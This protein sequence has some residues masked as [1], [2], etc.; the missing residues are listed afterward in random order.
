[1]NSKRNCWIRQA[2]A[3][4]VYAGLPGASIAQPL[5][6][7]ASHSA[8]SGPAT[9][10]H[11]TII[12]SSTGN[13][14][15]TVNLGDAAGTPTWNPAVVAA[16]DGS[17]VYVTAGPDLVI[18]N[19]LTYVTERL[20]LG[21][22]LGE[23]A[24]SADGSRLYIASNSHASIFVVDTATLQPAG[25]PIAV[26]A[27]PRQLALT[28]DGTRLYVLGTD[29]VYVADTTTRAV[30]ASLATRP[31]A[32]RIL[33]HPDGSRLY[34]GNA[35]GT[36]TSPD[37]NSITSYDTSTLAEIKTTVFPDFRF[38]AGFVL[39]PA[40][41][42]TMAILP[43]GDRLYVPLINAGFRTSPTAFFRHEVVHVVDSQT[44]DITAS[45]TPIRNGGTAS[46]GIAAAVSPGGTTVFVGVTGG[47]SAIEVGT[48]AVTVAGPG[49]LNGDS[50]AAA[51]APPCWFELSPQ[52][53][54]VRGA[55]GSVTLNVPAPEG[56]AWNA[57]VNG[58]PLPVSATSGT[59]SSTITLQ[60]GSSDVPRHWTVTIAGQTLTIDQVISRTSIETPP[61]GAGLPLPFD[62][63]GWTIEQDARVPQAFHSGVVFGHLYDHPV[64]GPAVFLGAIGTANR[65]PDIA[66]I[67]GERY[68]FSGF[69]KRIGRLSA[70][71]HTL[72]VYSLSRND[73]Q[74]FGSA[75]NVT[76]RRE[77]QIV[78]DSPAQ[79]ATVNQ[80]FKLSGWAADTTVPVGSGVDMVRVSARRG[81]GTVIQLGNATY[82]INRGDVS[83]YFFD[84]GFLNLGFEMNVSGL[85]AGTYTLVAEAR[86]TATGLFEKSASVQV[87]VTGSAPFGVIDTPAASA[88]V[89]G[90]VLVT[91]WALSDVGVAR[92]AVYRD[93]VA[94]ESGQ[95]WIG[96][97]TFVDGARPDVAA[98][99]PSY[100]QNTRAGW[101][102]AVLTNMLPSG[103][104]GPITFHVYAHD[105]NNNVTALGARSV[106]GANGSSVQP[107]GTIDTPGQGATVSGTITVFGW[108]LT[109]GSNIIPTDGST[110]QVVVD[111]VV[112]GQPTYNQCRG[113]NGT[114]FPPPGTCNDDIAAAFGSAYRNIAAGSGAIGS[115]ELDT[116][117]L[118]NGIHSIEW[119]VTDS[120]GNVQGIGSRYFYVQNGG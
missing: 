83:L 54:Y 80:P 42:G 63:T 118:S 66:A 69:S 22:V 90:T 4:L 41:I 101:G 119:R 53:S 1:M 46:T 89:A 105:T 99:F 36:T 9:S 111:S 102:L 21:G 109:P 82:G 107:F 58:Q 57:T 98:A 12:N 16:S 78:I 20:T 68:A 8:S 76:V 28:S 71:A 30:T 37:G 86:Y 18:V 73:G 40:G 50:L 45:I 120:A 2:L 62:L 106:V 115:F 38:F 48:N 17:R 95:V 5:V 35:T 7:V 74:F 91:G 79:G 97:A 87:T 65:R 72:V 34:V 110:I 117:A 52:Q 61:H 112:V 6:Y 60:V 100:P 81:D 49:V 27:T 75:V 84:T 19:A 15:N 64:G 44:L 10:A 94:G 55:G 14:V 23:L 13:V 114:N 70:G 85:P 93:P 59:G 33:V 43:S 31:A 67:Y 47:L 103:G 108:A 26:A 96:D 25:S 104:N 56:C 29:T 3:C 92:V 77:P 32:V 51:P 24:L 11:L 113:T 39:S 116:T 88:S